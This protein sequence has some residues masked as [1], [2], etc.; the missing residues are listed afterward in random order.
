VT[1]SDSRS[2]GRLEATLRALHYVVNI[3]TVALSTAI[4]GTD[5]VLRYVFNAPL[6]WSIEATGLLLL[7]MVFGSLPYVWQRGGH[8][9]MELIY[10][11]LHGVPKVIAD[12]ATAVSGGLFSVLLCYEMFRTFPAMRAR[13]EGAENLGVPYWPFALFIAIVAAV[14]TLQF[15]V[16]AVRSTAPNRN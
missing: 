12:L 5:V 14:M 10:Q 6:T 11:R 7:V 1:H 2:D 9:R 8:I 3:V 13:H 16:F 15:I 4:I